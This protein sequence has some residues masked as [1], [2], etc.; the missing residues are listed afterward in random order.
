MWRIYELRGVTM[1]Q[2]LI[3]LLTVIFFVCSLII[4]Q[5]Y[6]ILG[7]ALLILG[8]IIC[9]IIFFKPS[10]KEIENVKKLTEK[11]KNRDL[12]EDEFTRYLADTNSD[13]SY[14]LNEFILAIKEYKKSIGSII[15]I[16]N[17]VN[18][19]ADES[20]DL[21][22][23]LMNI[24]SSIAGGA[25]QQAGDTEAALSLLV[26]LTDRFD[27]MFNCV[28]ATENDVNALKATSTAGNTSISFSIEKNNEMKK[29]F[30]DAMEIF[31]ELQSS[32]NNLD[33]IVNV[34][35]S[36]SKQINLLS[37]NASIEAAR[38]GEAGKG[39][40]VVA[41]EIRN[42]ADQSVNSGKEI[43]NSISQIKEKINS[44]IDIVKLLTGK[45]EEQLNAANE[46]NNAFVEIENA[47]EN[48]VG[49]LNEL[50][51][52]VFKLRDTKNLVVDSIT[53]ISA[54]AQQSV[55]ATE[56]A[57][58]FTEMQK[59][60]SEILHD[61]ADKLKFTVDS[62]KE[63]IGN[64]TVEEDKEKTKKIAFVHSV[65]ENNPYI[66]QMI[67]NGRETALK[68]GYDFIVSCPEDQRVE[69]QIKTVENLESRG[70]DYL[71]L[72][73]VEPDKL[74]PIINRLDEKGIKTIC[75]DSDAP[76]SKRLC[77]ISTDN[78]AAGNNVGK[79]IAK[80]LKGKGK[81]IVSLITD[82]QSN[83]AERLRGVKEELKKYKDISI[84][85]TEIGYTDN[86]ERMKNME[87][88]IKKYPDFNLMAGI[89]A[90]YCSIIKNLKSRNDLN[91][92]IFI[93]FDNV[94]ENIELLKNGTIDSIIAQR[95]ELFANLAVRKIYDYEM[96]RPIDETIL[97]DT[98]EIN[99]TNVNSIIS[100]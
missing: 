23:T 20:S 34:I 56:E 9:I 79:V 97:M 57:T 28:S 99:K 18:Q 98:Y 21:S 64:Y 75:I 76:K 14:I 66:R 3:K 26:D 39:F 83:I 63:K 91:D 13:L 16:S 47:V 42:L 35:G 12:R 59:Q 10:E 54:V 92:K 65:K 44:T 36:I 82:K 30:L 61:I 33:K 68:Y 24:N 29:A 73:P 22:K 27:K 31:T 87:N 72:A 88:L 90:N 19:S 48:V 53:N 100:R 40:G 86:N 95:Q 25:E 58:S 32:I 50:K 69:S 94:A 46:V 38:A 71:I 17:A 37:L 1:K 55:A 93:G 62:A 11:I 74:T 70:I 45:S 7:N 60:S 43:G 51:D 49:Q 8:V 77:F 67:K 78:Y 52:N 5:F 41:L 89:E 85:A 4:R 80:R 2:K 6:D 81:V 84:I 96:H 15:N